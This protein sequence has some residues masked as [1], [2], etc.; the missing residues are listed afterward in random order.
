MILP[1]TSALS[2][3]RVRR[4]IGQGRGRVPLA[5]GV[6]A[7]ATLAG[8]VPAEWLTPAG[9]APGTALLFL[10]GGGW[11]LG[12]DSAHRMLSAQLAQ[13]A[14][15]RTLSLEYRLAPE[16]PFPAALLD[17]QAAFGWLQ[18]EGYPANRIA[19]SGDSAGANLAVALAL[20]LKQRGLA[21]P[22]AIAGLSGAYDL[23]GAGATFHTMPDAMLNPGYMLA[24]AAHYAAGHDR[25]DPLLSPLWGDLAGL[26]PLLLQA[27]DHEM[28]L[29]DSTRL[30]ERAQAAG[31][32]VKLSIYP[33][34]WH[35]WHVWAPNLPEAAAA[36]REAAQFVSAAVGAVE[37]QPS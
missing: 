23:E 32:P 18:T 7:E 15:L 34:M 10:H 26:P 17:C 13:A 5:K 21:L 12:L 1:A 11:T 16:H 31:V 2:L 20:A 25:H 8:G 19:V 33:G 35:A 22:G 14:G 27:G 3:R 4:L 24:M 28:L 30:A 29:S 6:R 9:A 37:Q 36:V